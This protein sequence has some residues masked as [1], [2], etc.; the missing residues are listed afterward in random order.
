[1]TDLIVSDGDCVQIL[2]CFYADARIKFF[3]KSSNHKT[4][5][6][7]ISEKLDILANPR[8]LGI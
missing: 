7:K 2:Q 8:Q 1:M 5:V 6:E 3:Q 4:C